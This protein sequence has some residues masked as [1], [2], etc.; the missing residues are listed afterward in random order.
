VDMPVLRDAPAVIRESLLFPYLGGVAFM[1]QYWAAAGGRVAPLAE[2]MPES[3]EQILHPERFL[4]TPRDSPTLVTYTESPPRG[5]TEAYSDGM[6]ELETRIFLEEYL[7]SR[8]RAESA[9]AGWDGD[10]Y[11][12]LEGPDGEVLVWTSVWDT[13][14]DAAEFEATARRAFDDRYARDG[15]PTG[16]SVTVHRALFEG[17]PTVV[18]VDRPTTV[19]ETA[20]VDARAFRLDGD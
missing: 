8:S 6:G 1:Q 7:G 12:L 14:D 10:R 20:L 11:R 3:T 5:W 17:R 19:A 16:R 18:V 4:S 9:A 15:A 13:D 2:R